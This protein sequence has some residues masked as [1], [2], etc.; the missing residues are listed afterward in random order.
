[1]TRHQ[2]KNRAASGPQSCSEV[3]MRLRESAPSR[4]AVALENS[5]AAPPARTPLA[6]EVRGLFLPDL[7]ADQ[8]APPSHQA[9]RAADKSS[10]L[11]RAYDEFCRRAATG[12]TPDVEGFCAEYP[13]FKTSLR[14]LL[15]AHCL[16]EENPHLLE[17]QSEVC[18]PEPGQAFLGFT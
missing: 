16:L 15:E 9:R 11:D 6:A 13:A 8:A 14:K 12:A 10:Y 2:R 4:P 3:V 17:E 18:W 7:D 5:A 1:S